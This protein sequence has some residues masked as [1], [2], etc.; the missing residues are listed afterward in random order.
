MRKIK[1]IIIH[2]S[3]TVEGKD[4]HVED[5]RRWHKQQGWQD[6]GYHYII[7]LDGTV[8]EGRR[9]ELAGAHANGH[10][11]D[12]I[13]IC[14]IGGLAP[15]GKTAKDT[16]TDAQKKSLRFLVDDLKK[17]FANVE[18]LG[19]NNLTKAKACPCFDA[20]KEFA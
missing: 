7:A 4:F 11:A 19:H 8:E 12:S 3:A 10:N 15:D 18:V 13:G 9:L 1:K 2:C 16:R 5:V 14:Y 20:K 6:V 17:R